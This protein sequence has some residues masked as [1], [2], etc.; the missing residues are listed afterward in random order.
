M[1]LDR[2]EVEIVAHLARLKVSDDQ[3]PATLAS[4]N[5]I[6]TLVDRMQEIDT[7]GIEPLANPL[8]ATARL[9][10]DEVTETNHRD[11]YQRIAPSTTDG[12]YLV[13]KVIE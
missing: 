10:A 12:L 9:R 11:D 6:L 3:M 5:S 4:L 7:S 13:P 1:S 2:N 8:D